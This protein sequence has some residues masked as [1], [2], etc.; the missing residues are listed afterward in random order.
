MLYVKL[1]TFESPSESVFANY[2][3]TIGTETN[4]KVDEYTWIQQH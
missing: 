4:V 1:K 2:P 3:K